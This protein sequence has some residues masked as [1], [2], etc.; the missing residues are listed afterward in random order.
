MTARVLSV[1]AF[2][3]SL[4]TAVA[5]QNNPITV[6]V[7]TV[8]SGD[9]AVIGANIQRTI[10]TYNERYL[11]HPIKFVFEDARKGSVDGLTA[12]RKLVEGSKVDV[13]IEATT[14][15]GTLAGAPIIN[16]NKVPLL[17]PVTGESNIDRAGEFIFR[18]GNRTY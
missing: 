8:L 16:K 1:I 6:G 13:L 9:A 11:R 12:Y 2:L 5:D 17:T 14:S 3:V 4:A 7:A 10:S 15:N 18:I